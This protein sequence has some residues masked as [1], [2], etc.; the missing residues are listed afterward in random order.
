[1]IKTVFQKIQ[2]SFL[3]NVKK[4]QKTRVLSGILSPVVFLKSYFSIDKIK[5]SKIILRLWFKCPEQVDL[6][7]F[8]ENSF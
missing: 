7:L 3:K 6:V 8:R 2:I 4:R 1:M 5:K